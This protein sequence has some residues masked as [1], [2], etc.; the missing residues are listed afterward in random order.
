[1]SDSGEEYY[2]DSSEESDSDSSGWDDDD[3]ALEQAFLLAITLYFFDPQP[4]HSAAD[5]PRTLQQG[6]DRFTDD[7]FLKETRFSKEQIPYLLYHLQVP[8]TITIEG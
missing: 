3:E 1:M 6:M 5:K 4:Y 8:D 7:H 2:I